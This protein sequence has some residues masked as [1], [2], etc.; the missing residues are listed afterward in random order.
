MDDY[1]RANAKLIT[2]NDLTNCPVY[3][4]PSTRRGWLKLAR[5]QAR[6][7]LREALKNEVSYLSKRSTEG[8]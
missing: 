8:R 2:A 1:K 6:R 3:Y 5:R 4:R 7:K